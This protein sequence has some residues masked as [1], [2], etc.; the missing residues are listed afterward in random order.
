M[1]L[2][3]NILVFSSSQKRKER[4]NE[5]GGKGTGP[6]NPKDF[7]SARG[8]GPCN[9][10]GKHAHLCVC[11]SVI[12]SNKSAVG[13]QTPDVWRT[14]SLLPTLAPTNCGQTAPGT[15]TTAC[16]WMEGGRRVAAAKLKAEI[17][18]N[19]LSLSLEVGKP[20]IDS[21]VPK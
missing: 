10:G 5:G 6:L 17:D 2:L 12:R 1:Q 3:L 14:V 7:A 4:K 20:S 15:H 9:K 16:H 8:G 11:T 18:Q 13:T 19:C 21:S